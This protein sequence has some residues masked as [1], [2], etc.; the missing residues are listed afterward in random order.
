M[1][2]PELSRDLKLGADGLRRI[3]R[4]LLIVLAV[5]MVLSACGNAS[6]GVSLDQVLNTSWAGYKRN[7]ITRDGR[8]VDHERGELTSSEAQSYAMLRAVWMDDQPEFDLVWKWTRT[9]L[10][11]RGDRLFAFLWGKSPGTSWHG[12]SPDSAS[13]ADE[14]TALALIFAGHLWQDQAYLTAAHGVLQDIWNKEVARVDGTPYLA[15]GDWAA[16]WP[17]DGGLVINP[18]YLAPA[19]YRIFQTADP[20]HAWSSLVDSSYQALAKCSNS[21]L[22]E[23]TDPHHEN[24]SVGL[25]P[26]WCLLVKGGVRPYSSQ[27]DGDNY[28]YD[29]FRVMWRVALDYEWF[30]APQ[31]TAYLEHS[32]FLRRQ[33]RANGSLA[34]IYTHDGRP[35]GPPEDPI[36]YGG[37]IGNFAVVDPPAAQDILQDKLLTATR[38]RRGT[39]YFGDP[40]NYYQQNWVWF[41]IALAQHQLPNLEKAPSGGLQ[42][43]IKRRDIWS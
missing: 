38:F 16:R 30:Q 19:S 39:I 42:V 3:A 43:T 33:W 41:G 2:R 26:N 18:S 11:V 13:D 4:S 7:F 8:V 6:G 1:A 35:D 40:Q 12:V 29:A 27:W 5:S 10:E 15:A 28:G 23:R 24:R 32:S 37:D 20:A 9:H 36:I 34:A 17:T 22:R 21:A 14:D 31:A 25:P